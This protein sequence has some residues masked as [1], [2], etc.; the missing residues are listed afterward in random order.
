MLCPATSQEQMEM[1]MGELQSVLSNSVIAAAVPSAGL[2][3]FFWKGDEAISTEFKRW[4]GE[5]I[6]GIKLS[7]GRVGIEP[8][9]RVFDLIYG[10][11]Y[12][13]LNTILRV[14][15]VSTVAAVISFTVFVLLGQDAENH[16]RDIFGSQNG[17][18]AFLVLLT[19]NGAFDYISVTKARIIMDK[20]VQSDLRYKSVV[21]LL[22][23][24]IVTIGI[25]EAYRYV[26]H[27]LLVYFFPWK[28][29]GMTAIFSLLPLRYLF[30]IYAFI[31][32]TFLMFFLTA[33][34]LMSV[35]SLI[36]I[37][38]IPAL[39][40]ILWVLPVRDLPIRSIGLMSGIIMF[41]GVGLFGLFGQ[42]FFRL[43]ARVLFLFV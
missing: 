23:D 17:I 28:I 15:G 40:F 38:A 31:S 1:P 27:D 32:T 21:F 42:F 19:L 22:A 18:A 6:S 36:A 8:L 39:S 4:L 2:I 37:C 43:L 13:S 9:G 10:R 24:A 16:I 30:L 11:P 14:T 35:W 5:R 29:R 33:M 25:L 20:V 12:F 34:Y 26:A 41:I 7:A 3:A